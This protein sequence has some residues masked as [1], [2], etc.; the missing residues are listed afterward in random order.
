V[1]VQAEVTHLRDQLDRDLLVTWLNFARGTFG[2]FESFDTDAD[3]TPDMTFSALM[4]GAETIRMSPDADA[5]RQ[6]IETLRALNTGRVGNVNRYAQDR[7]LRGASTPGQASQGAV[8]ASDGRDMEQEIEGVRCTSAPAGMMDIAFSA[9][10]G[11]TV[12]LGVFD[13][14]GRRIRS[15][16]GTYASGIHHIRWDGR[17]ESG[18]FVGS[19]VYILVLEKQGVVS[20]AKGI[21]MR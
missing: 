15:F 13:I 3:Q 20:H 18:R 17:S 10:A 2:Y 16:D 19:G 4:D 11:A 21:L 12:R 8:A 5:L 9:P 6:E 7:T 14:G 1:T